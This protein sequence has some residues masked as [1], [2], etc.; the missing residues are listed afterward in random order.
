MRSASARLKRVNDEL[1]LKFALKRFVGCRLDCC[2]NAG[3]QRAKRRVRASCGF[4]YLNSRGDKSW[5]G[6][7]AGY[8]K[9]L[10]GASRLNA[11]IDTHRYLALAE[12]IFFS[13]CWYLARM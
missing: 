12:R 7:P 1:I 13:P 4:L 10:D 2:G 11:V 9:V 6:L 3:I 8:G 5:K